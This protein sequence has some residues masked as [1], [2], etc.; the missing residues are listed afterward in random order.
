M[1]TVNQIATILQ[2]PVAIA[3][4]WIVAIQQTKNEGLGG[5]IG[6]KVQSSF[7][8]KPAFEERLSDLTRNI[9]I[10]FFVISIVVAVTMNR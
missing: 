3:M 6:G 5:T 4:I 8:G 2:I 1:S 10:A 7:K 9:G